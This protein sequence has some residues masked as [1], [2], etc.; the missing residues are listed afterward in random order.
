MDTTAIDTLYLT[1]LKH[2]HSVEKQ[3]VK[4]LEK[5]AGTATNAQLKAAFES[6]KSESQSH[7]ERLEQILTGLG[8]SAGRKKAKDIEAII[9]H[10]QELIDAQSEESARDLAL[11]DAAQRTEHHEI[12]LYGCT[13]AYAE[14]LGRHD[15][16][17]TLHTT[18][19][20][21]KRADE[22]LTR[23]AG[24]IVSGDES[25]MPGETEDVS[26]EL[27]MASA[28]GSNEDG[29]Q[30]AHNRASTGEARTNSGSQS[31][32]KRRSTMTRRNE[33]D[34]D[35]ND[36][37]TRSGNRTPVNDRDDYGR[38]NTYGDRGAG[39]SR[40]DENERTYNRPNGARYSTSRYEEDDYSRSGPYDGRS[41][42][43]RYSSEMQERD[44]YG[45]YAGPRNGNGNGGRYRSDDDDRGYSQ[46]NGGRYSSSSRYDDEDYDRTGPYEA[47]TRNER[48]SR[49]MHTRDEF[50][51]FAGYGNGNGGSRYRNDDDR[52]DNRNSSGRRGNGRSSDEYV[53]AAGRH[54]SR[55]SW[56]RAQEG[57]SLGGQHSHGSRR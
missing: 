26:P 6:H 56:E 19:E 53:D 40:D 14:H 1:N 31:G 38:Y 50:G 30:R 35:N 17:R 28:G 45:Q 22:K 46:S 12:A 5:L 18:L 23:L 7:V 21:E 43:G 10:G 4:A 52:D 44:E 34:Y 33:Y 57:R 20:E 42:G 29:E 15:D 2:L 36:T 8:Q 48:E 9:T 47:R 25:S 27:A 13:A 51:Q 55:E 37:R 3:L 32:T 16:A 11:I 54:Y 24:V 39:R 49:E 41:R